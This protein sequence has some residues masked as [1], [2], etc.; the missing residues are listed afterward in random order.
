M[1]DRAEIRQLY[2]SGLSLREIS[3]RTNI[4]RTSLRTVLVQDGIN[5][6][7]F[8]KDHKQNDNQALLKQGMGPGSTSYGFTFLDGKL[9]VEPREYKVILEMQRLLKSGIGY[10]EIA[11]VLND[12]GV[13]TRLGKTWKY[14]TVRKIISRHEKE[15][16]QKIG[17]SI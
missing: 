12:R 3:L 7:N 1:C 6:R 10:L 9:V 16:A 17:D 11:K 5:L 2:E 15:M 4:P 14:E 8:R 13:P